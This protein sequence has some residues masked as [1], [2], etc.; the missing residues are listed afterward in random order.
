[1]KGATDSFLSTR[2]AV[3]PT[4]CCLSTL[5]EA[6]KAVQNEISALCTTFTAEGNFRPQYLHYYV[7]C[8]FSILCSRLFVTQP[9]RS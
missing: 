4:H 7:P 2:N 9:Y 1:M 3:L 8:F 6:K 5:Q